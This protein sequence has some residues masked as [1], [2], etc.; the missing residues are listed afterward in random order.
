MMRR[1]VRSGL[2]R[3]SL[4]DAMRSTGALS[5]A[6]SSN[7]FLNDATLSE[8]VRGGGGGGALFGVL[9]QD[10]SCFCLPKPLRTKAGGGLPNGFAI[11]V[12]K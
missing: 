3:R 6:F 12:C 5:F 10:V 2:L 1:S 9:I 7:K 8:G 11:G 4:R